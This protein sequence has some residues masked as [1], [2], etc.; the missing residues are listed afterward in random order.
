LRTQ[1]LNLSQDAFAEAFNLPVATLRNFEQARC[2]PDAA[3][4]AY[5]K[6]IVEAP[7]LVRKALA[8]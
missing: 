7:D 6:V 8:A 5:L 3:L 4:E 1:T 2:R